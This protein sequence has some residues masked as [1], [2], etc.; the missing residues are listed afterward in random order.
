MRIAAVALVIVA[1]LVADSLRCVALA[2]RFAGEP[3]DDGVA[4]G[5]GATSVLAASGISARLA[6]SSS[7]DEHSGDRSAMR[8]SS[9]GAV[10]ATQIPGAYRST[11]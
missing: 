2:H 5:Q 1:L 10:A 8:A 9:Y 3:G 6:D 7:R 4:W 11:R